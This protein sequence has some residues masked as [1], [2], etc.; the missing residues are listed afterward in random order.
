M[1]TLSAS[2]TLREIKASY[3]DNASYQEDESVPKAKAFITACRMLLLQLPKR[4]NLANRNEIEIDTKLLPEQIEEAKAWIATN[5]VAA[6]AVKHSSFEAF[7][8]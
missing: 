7:R 4:A 8:N 2:S 5:D 3:L 1:S 6:G